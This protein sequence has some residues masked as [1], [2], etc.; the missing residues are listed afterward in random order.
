M[1]LLEKDNII[2]IVVILLYLICVSLFAI[3]I[4]K[5]TVE[6]E[7]FLNSYIN[8]MFIAFVPVGLL[9]IFSE[10][11]V[12]KMTI[13]DKFKES[14]PLILVTVLSIPFI[15]GIVAWISY[16]FK[17]VFVLIITFW[18][19]LFVALIIYLVLIFG[20]LLKH[21]FFKQKGRH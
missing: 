11:M 17:I 4:Y 10:K 9:I 20:S 1:K 18:K 15:S 8:Y 3:F 16:L 21:K 14:I 2:G 12:E 7:E 6:N 5:K 19:I 13:S